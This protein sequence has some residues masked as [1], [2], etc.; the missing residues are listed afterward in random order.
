MGIK[1]LSLMIWN[2]SAPGKLRFAYFLFLLVIVIGISHFVKNINDIIWWYSYVFLG[3]LI[4]L[5]LAAYFVYP[6]L[7]KKYR[8]GSIFEYIMR[9]NPDWLN[10]VGTG[11]A[12]NIESKQEKE[13]IVMAAKQAQRVYNTHLSVFNHI[14]PVI[15][16]TILTLGG[17]FVL[18]SRI[19]PLIGEIA[20]INELILKIPS[21]IIYGF[22]GSNLFVLYS[23]VS[24]FRS[25]DITPIMILGMSYQI[26]LSTT[27]A[28][29]LATLSTDLADP[30]VAFLIGFV[31]FADLAK[32][33]TST[34]KEKLGQKPLVDQNQEDLLKK[35]KESLFY[36]QGMSRKDSER[37]QEEGLYTIQDLALSNPMTLYLIT[38]FKM[39]QL[40]E[41]INQA[42]LQTFLGKEA[43][44]SL[45]PMGIHGAIG[46]RIKA[47]NKEIQGAA[48]YKQFVELIATTT[49]YNKAIIESLIERLMNDSRVMLLEV[50]WE[51]YGSE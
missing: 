13:F 18:F 19:N 45:A 35:E 3:G 25:T 20:L 9:D 46:V 36:L 31:P 34:S 33:F 21:P 43:S 2:A 24:R 5:F 32:W 6:A 17:N 11:K 48:Q 7:S 22:I 12:E 38:P 8:V 40:V 10:I 29:V 28:Y 27:A 26:I 41:W 16:I 23:I 37:L 44:A 50:L 4:P 39:S 1:S 15:F 51:E 14:L 42:Y 49:T 47:R 30:F